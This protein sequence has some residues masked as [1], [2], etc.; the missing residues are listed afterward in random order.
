[1]REANTTGRAR[2]KRTR[3]P[4]ALIVLGALSAI[5]GTTF[6]ARAGRDRSRAADR[7]AR[8]ARARRGGRRAGVRRD[9]RRRSRAR[10]GAPVPPLRRRSLVRRDA[11]ASGGRVVRLHRVGTDPRPPRR[12]P[13]STTSRRATR[14][15]TASSRATR[16]AP[17]C[18]ASGTG[19][20]PARPPRTR[21]ASPRRPP[22]EPGAGS[23]SGSACSPWVRRPAALSDDGSDPEAGPNTFTVTLD[24]PG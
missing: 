23:T 13:S 4:L 12:A 6:A 24:S 17:W 15:A 18:A 10:R 19:R 21:P 16:S 7:R 22:E 5:G 1:M 3:V 9:G 20:R 11:D 8:G 2:W 14:P